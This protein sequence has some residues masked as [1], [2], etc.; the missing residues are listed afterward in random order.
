MRPPGP[1]LAPEPASARL[2]LASASIVRRP[3]LLPRLSGCLIARSLAWPGL[4]WSILLSVPPFGLIPSDPR[5]PSRA[6]DGSVQGLTTLLNSTNSAE[7]LR[8]LGFSDQETQ[9]LR[10]LGRVLGSL[11]ASGA[12]Q[13]QQQQ[14]PGQ[15]KQQPQ[16]KHSCRSCR[17]EVP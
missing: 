14:H 16:Q 6:Q 2:H 3:Q 7:Q 1:R 8:E 15:Q 11:D 12:Q 9:V 5:V 13:Q 10:N 17:L 4:A